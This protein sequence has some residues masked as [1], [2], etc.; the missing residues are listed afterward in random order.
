MEQEK[1][2]RKGYGLQI[3]YV[4]IL[5]ACLPLNFLYFWLTELIFGETMSEAQFNLSSTLYL[6]LTVI[7]IIAVLALGILNIIHS[8]QT[9]HKKDINY[10]V[11]SLLILKYG[12]VIFFILNYLVIVLSLA[13]GGL[14]SMIASRGLILF[15]L[16]FMLPGIIVLIM[17]LAFITWLALVPGAF[18]GISVIRL[19]HSA[20]KTGLISSLFHTILQFTFLLDVLDTMYLSVKKWNLGRKS[21]IVIGIVYLMSVALVVWSAVSLYHLF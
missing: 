6:V 21:S 7:Y 4:T 8:F 2:F 3:G 18:Y 12:L 19:T 20:Q 1:H 15:T 16:P 5:T 9:C 17:F 14:I 10:S 11:N 13:G